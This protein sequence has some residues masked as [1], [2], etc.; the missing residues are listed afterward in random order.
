MGRSF[1]TSLLLTAPFRAWWVAAKCASSPLGPRKS[2]PMASEGCLCF[3][4]PQQP[5]SVS[6]AILF[7]LFMLRKVSCF[8]GMCNHSSSVRI[9]FTSNQGV[10]ENRFSFCCYSNI[11]KNCTGNLVSNYTADKQPRS[12]LFPHNLVLNPQCC[13]KLSKW[14]MR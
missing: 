10:T 9:Y 13:R 1:R 2:L 3:L 6:C 4:F 7:V 14:W 8:R 5:P 11:F 12:H